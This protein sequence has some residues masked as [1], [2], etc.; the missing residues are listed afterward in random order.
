[1]GDLQEGPAEKRRGTHVDKT[2]NDQESNEERD[3]VL[4]RRDI[5]LIGG[6]R[7]SAQDHS[8]QSKLGGSDSSDLSKKVEPSDGPEEGTELARWR[9]QCG[10]GNAPSDDGL[11]P[12]GDEVS[13][14]GVESSVGRVRLFAWV[15]WVR[16]T[17]QGQMERGTHGDNFCD[18]GSEAEA[19][20][21]CKEDRISFRAPRKE[22]E[23]NALPTNQHQTTAVSIKGQQ[24]EWPATRRDNAQAGP[25]ERRGVL[26]VVATEEATPMIENANEMVCR[27]YTRPHQ[28]SSQTRGPN[29]NAHL[30]S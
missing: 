2:V 1:M 12:L 23:N 20:E 18:G 11:V 15:S 27:Q 16:G 3:G 6:D 21:S 17:T 22:H 29:E 24:L 8:S 4:R 26:S 10:E 7:N 5:R 28:L 25:P 9:R 14:S 30:G 19:H 13:R